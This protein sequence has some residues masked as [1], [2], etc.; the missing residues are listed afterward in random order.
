MGVIEN[1]RNGGDNKEYL[2]SLG[3]QIRRKQVFIRSKTNKK[4]ESIYRKSLISKS[5]HENKDTL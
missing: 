1:K 2:I 5:H 4:Q 3:L